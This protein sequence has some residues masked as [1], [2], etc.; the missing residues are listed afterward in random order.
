MPCVGFEPMIPAS[1]R[2]K[3][4]HAL[5]RSATVT[6][7]NK[8]YLN[9][10]LDAPLILIKT[11]ASRDKLFDQNL[12][13]YRHTTDEYS[14]VNRQVNMLKIVF[15]YL[16]CILNRLIGNNRRYIVLITTILQGI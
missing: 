10:F 3:T 12:Y 9:K 11:P 8:T 6:G 13:M 7:L 15:D 14:N 1:E 2:A 16:P 5:D 4:V